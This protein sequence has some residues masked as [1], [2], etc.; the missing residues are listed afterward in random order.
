MTSY[1]MNQLATSREL[2]KDP[3]ASSHV[4]C[5]CSLLVAIKLSYFNR[6]FKH[7]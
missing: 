7:S 3:P 1:F 2:T 4:P 5:L 6:P